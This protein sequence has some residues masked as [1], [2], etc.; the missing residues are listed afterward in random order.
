MYHTSAPQG[1]LTIVESKDRR[2]EATERIVRK[3]TL[4]VRAEDYLVTVCDPE[5]HTSTHAKH[6]KPDGLSLEEV[7]GVR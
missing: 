2:P 7:V 1:T 3:G 6:S 5:D 4:Q